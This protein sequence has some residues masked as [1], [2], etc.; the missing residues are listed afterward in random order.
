MLNVSNS[1]IM[2]LNRLAVLINI[3]LWDD[4]AVKSN[5]QAVY[6]WVF[7]DLLFVGCFRK[8]AIQALCAADG[9]VRYSCLIYS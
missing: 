6:S 8:I 5:I 7:F 1:G 4:S 9:T 3:S 2:N